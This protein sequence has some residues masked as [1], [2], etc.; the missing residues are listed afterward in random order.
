MQ[1]GEVEDGEYA[2][3]SYLGGGGGHDAW[4]HGEW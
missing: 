1:R 2:Y 3:G 4:L